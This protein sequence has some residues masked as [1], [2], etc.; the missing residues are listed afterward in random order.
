MYT[1]TK[2]AVDPAQPYRP[3]FVGTLEAFVNVG[4]K[5]RRYLAYIPEG[6]RE[7]T[8]GVLVLGANGRTADDLWRESAWRGL[9][10]TEE[11]KEKLIVIFLEPEDGVWKTGEPYGARDGDVAYVDAVQLAAAE[12]LHFCIHESK[13]YLFGVREGGTMAHMA[14]MDNP[15]VYAGV[16]SL[17]GSAVPDAYLA[18]CGGAPCTNLDGFLDET[19]RQGRKKGEIPMPVW[20]IA[21]PDSPS[22]E[23]PA[24]AAYWKRACGVSGRSRQLAP[25]TTEFVREAPT[26]F[27]CNQEREAYRV[28]ESVLPG[29]SAAD[30]AR[31]SRRVWKEFLSRQRRWM[32]DPGGDLRVT[33]DP[34]ADLGM[35]YHYE[36]IG[37]WMREWYVYVPDT[38]RARPETPAPVVIA[39]H[40]YTCSGEIY[41]G[42]SEWYKVARDRGFLVIHP[43]AV[44]GNIEMENQACSAQN[45]P[46]PAWNFLHNA[47]DGPDDIA[48]LRA[49]LDKT[50]QAHAIDRT[51]VYATGHS[52][53]SMMTQALALAVPEL[54]AA[55]A[56]CSGV[57]FGGMGEPL[58]AQPEIAGR[59]DLPVPIWMFGGEQEPWLLP[60]LPEPGNDTANT[61]DLW[62]RLNGLGD[63]PLADFSAGWS[64]HADRWHDLAY[65]DE[66]GAPLVKYT[67]VDYMPHATMTEMSYRI[68]DEFFAH[69]SREDGKI[70]YR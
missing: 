33:R 18:A 45:V 24:V 20:L 9:A 47:P 38:V 51:R 3:V 28:C 49:V 70:V 54:L 36:E 60:Y 7:S 2:R 27:P 37:G 29:A 48:F 59:P 56:P 42:N 35:E 11:R 67:W 44:D 12:R 10:D 31:L 66:S 1:L 65:R 63:A 55:A 41:A 15:A 43:T 17:G 39:M 64:V 23:S 26:E 52:H 57:L 6:A 5:K 61:I 69:F 14:A 46:L 25:D 34:V 30:G 16:A 50:A 13:F 68:W 58:L 8:A 19:A 40:G 21:D 32:A 53:G 22:G 4:G 62:R